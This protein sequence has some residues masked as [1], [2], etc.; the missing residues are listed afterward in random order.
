MAGLMSIITI[1]N[2]KG[3]CGKTVTATNLSVGL[4]RAGKRV[5]VIDLDPQA[6]LAVGLR[7]TPPADL[8][9]IADAI[10]QRRLSEIVVE[11]PT[12]GLSLVP[13]DMSLDPQSLAQELM[14]DTIVERALR[15]LAGG[16]DF[17]LLD[18]PPN[19]DL[20]TLNAI[21]AADWL[22]LPCD[23]DR[24]SLT[25]LTRTLE[26]TL[27]CLQYRPHIDP[28][29]FYK[30]L[31]TIFDDRDRT[32]NTWFEEQLGRL[33]NP[34][35]RARIHRATAFKKARAHGL[36]IFDYAEKYPKAGAGRGVEDFEQLTEEVL[37]YESQRRDSD[38]RR[39]TVHAG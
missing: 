39:D 33:E 3:G 4:A 15:P 18:T 12:P 1:T 19:L 31:V 7:V 38:E 26:V 28:A 20:V 35:F 14:R 8:L 30:V 22:I 32:V 25:S 17:V 34:P 21:M 36:S 16:F 37:A 11:T 6:P 10:K 5:L 27:K 9:P 2:Q 13:G 29:T 23:V 24:E